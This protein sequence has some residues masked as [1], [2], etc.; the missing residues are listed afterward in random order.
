MSQHKARAKTNPN[1]DDK[2]TRRLSLLY[3]TVSAAADT[4]DAAHSPDHVRGRC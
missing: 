3:P 1:T 2:A 4:E